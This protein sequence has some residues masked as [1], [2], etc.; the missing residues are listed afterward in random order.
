MK[1]KNNL[2][3]RVENTD[4]DEIRKESNH[5]SSLFN[6]ILRTIAVPIIASAITLTGCDKS[7]QQLTNTE[8]TECNPCYRDGKLVFSGKYL[9][10]GEFEIYVIDKKDKITKQLTDIP[11]IDISPTFSSDGK[12]VYFIHEGEYDKEKM[13]A[14]KQIFR[15]PSSGGPYKFTDAEA[16]TTENEQ[17]DQFYV[18]KKGTKISTGSYDKKGTVYINGKQVAG[19]VGTD[20]SLSLNEKE[21]ITSY[22]SRLYRQPTDGS[23]SPVEITKKKGYSCPNLI[24]DGPYNGNILAVYKSDKDKY[25]FVLMNSN[26]DLISKKEMPFKS[27][28]DA[29]V[30]DDYKMVVYSANRDLYKSNLE[31]L[32]GGKK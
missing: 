22:E 30:S 18:T 24:E 26:G 9:G 21:L 31:N 29:K 27:L 2:E 23:K 6:Y 20:P 7:Y 10:S 8:C 16:I 32:F 17:I 3:Q 28:N 25:S 5:R 4:P 15:I 1:E 13:I 14:P 19:S 12:H 11:G